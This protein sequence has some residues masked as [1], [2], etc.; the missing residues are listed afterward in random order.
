MKSY[1]LVLLSLISGMLHA[2]WAPSSWHTSQNPVT[3]DAFKSAI[4][5][6]SGFF[7]LLGIRSIIK[8]GKNFYHNF[9][10]HPSSYLS[11]R[12]AEMLHP[13]N[14]IENF[15]AKERIV[16]LIEEQKEK[17]RELGDRNWFPSKEALLKY[18]LTHLDSINK[19]LAK[20]IQTITYGDLSQDAD[21]LPALTDGLPH[22]PTKSCKLTIEQVFNIESLN[23]TKDYI[24]TRKAINKKIAKLKELS[25]PGPLISQNEIETLDLDGLKRLSKDLS[26]TLRPLAI[27]PRI[28]EKR[29]VV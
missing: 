17:L 12:D 2:S 25:Y 4:F 28:K 22:D 16:N 27:A 29:S 19:H 10:S 8:T 26:D 14:A 5:L 18:D 21:L 7:G 3:R 6:S 15:K 20:E 1:V 13:K 11:K 23:N 24:R 9:Y